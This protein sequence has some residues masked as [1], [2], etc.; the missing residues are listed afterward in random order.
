MQ[1]LTVSPQSDRHYLLPLPKGMGPESPEL[2][3]FF[4]YEL[5]VGHDGSRWCTAQGRFGNPLR[6]TGVQHPVPQLRCSVQRTFDEVVVTAPFAT[7]IWEGRNVRPARTPHSK[8]QA[9]L[10][11]QVLQVDGAQWRNVLLE[12]ALGRIRLEDPNDVDPNTGDPRL[13]FGLMEFGQDDILRRLATLGLP[14]D[15][16]LSVIAVEL[17]PEGPQ[18]PFADPMGLDLGQVRILRASTLTA[19]PAICPPAAV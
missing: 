11:A 5:R 19:V 15:S 1:A 18:S 16:P 13:A 6:L 9:L 2:F 10:Y 12:R 14:L 4:V 17:L 7:P 3:G 8:L